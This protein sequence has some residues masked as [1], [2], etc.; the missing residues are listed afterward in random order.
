MIDFS[1]IVATVETTVPIINNSFQ[2]NRKKYNTAVTYMDGWYKVQLNGN[3]V[4]VIDPVFIEIDPIKSPT[5]K[6]YTYGT[7]IIFQNFDVAKRKL[8]KEIMTPLL[9]NPIDSFSAVEAYI[10]EDGN[11]FYKNHN[12]A[13]TQLIDIK[14]L[15]DDNKSVNSTK[16]VTPEL[17]TAYL[18]HE[19]QRQTYLKEMESLRKETEKLEYIRSLPGK[20]ETL[21]KNVGATLVRFTKQAKDRIEVIWTIDSYPN[22]FNSIIDATSFRVLEAG[23]CMSGDDKKHSVTSMIFTADDYAKRGKIY[24][25]RRDRW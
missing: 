23:Y 16:G 25:T 15:F 17:K 20:I 21:F 6:G 14:M 22:E 13:D 9:L 5:I 7:Q 4:K 2:Y 1:Q 3:T 11:L 10:W 19:I 8:N 12:I 24:Q 18:F